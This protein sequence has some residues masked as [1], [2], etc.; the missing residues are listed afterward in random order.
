MSATLKLDPKLCSVCIAT[1][2]T[3]P[4]SSGSAFVRSIRRVFFELDRRGAVVEFDDELERLVVEAR[5]HISLE[6]D[7]VRARSRILRTFEERGRAEWLAW[8]DDDVSLD[9]PGAAPFVNMIALGVEHDLD[10]IGAIIPRKHFDEPALIRAMRW[11]LNTEAMAAIGKVSASD[12]QIAK[13]ILEHPLRWAFSING[14]ALSKLRATPGY[15]PPHP[16]LWKVD[17]LGFGC[18]L[19]RRRAVRRVLES[20]RDELWTNDPILG[21]KTIVPFLLEIERSERRGLLSEDNAFWNRY[22]AIGGELFAYVGPGADR[23]VH[24]G[25]HGYSADLRVFD[26]PWKGQDHA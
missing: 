10:A 18:C 4:L 14:F 24:T 2:H 25:T 15:K 16:A 17:Q 6:Q 7:V 12:R 1:P 8:W 22:G 5:E 21:G 20:Y 13:E 3:T 23:F 26:P 9:D 11:A 19:L